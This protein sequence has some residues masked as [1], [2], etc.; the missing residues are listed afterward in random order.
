MASWLTAR[1]ENHIYRIAYTMTS[2]RFESVTDL[3]RDISEDPKLADELEREVA[4]RQLVKLL[5]AHRV[6]S[7]LSQKEVAERMKCTQSKIS[8][9]ESSVDND[10]RLGDLQ[11]YLDSIGLQIRLVIAPKSH[12]AVDEIKFHAS[13]IKQL[14][15]K[16]VKLASTDDTKL[17][18]GIA[19]FAC[20]EA[21]INLLKIVL[22]AAKHLPEHVLERLPTLMIDDAAGCLN[23]DEGT[24]H[25][26]DNREL[27]AT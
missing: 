13:C 26:N 23:D 12:K 7:D 27:A 20:V 19:K 18:E 15:L 11:Q 3:L 6:R 24:D 21:P 16:L 22:D 9:L 10:L 2:K 1:R 8:K 25:S 17:A 5:I 14:L 4:G